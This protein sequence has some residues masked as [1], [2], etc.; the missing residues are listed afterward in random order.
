[1]KRT[2]PQRLSNATLS[3]GTALDGR[4]LP[5]K[6]AS[7]AVEW[8]TQANVHSKQNWAAF[9]NLAKEEPTKPAQARAWRVLHLKYPD[10]KIPKKRSAA[11]ITEEINSWLRREPG[12]RRV[13]IST[14][15]RVLGRKSQISND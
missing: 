2:L 12:H 1:M 10:H 8:Q 7:L 5:D 13:S 9:D 4:L 15:Q 6:G 11:E 14:V 3:G